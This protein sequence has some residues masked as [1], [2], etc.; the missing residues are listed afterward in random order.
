[1]KAIAAVI[2][3]LVGMCAVSGNGITLG[4]TYTEPDTGATVSLTTAK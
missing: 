4:V 3:M 1:M 2:C